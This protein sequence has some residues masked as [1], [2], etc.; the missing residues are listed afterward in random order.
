LVRVHAVGWAPARF[1]SHMSR[2]PKPHE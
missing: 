1:K 2:S